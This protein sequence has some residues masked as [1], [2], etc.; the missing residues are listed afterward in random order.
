MQVTSH[1]DGEKII[2]LTREAIIISNFAATQEV[3]GTAITTSNVLHY[4]DTTPGQD[5]AFQPF[6]ENGILVLLDA[7]TATETGGRVGIYRLYPSF[8]LEIPD[9]TPA[10]TSTSTITYTVEDS[11]I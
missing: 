8:K 2:P 6:P 4:S 11:I 1:T 5:T 10:C 9:T 3:K 7:P